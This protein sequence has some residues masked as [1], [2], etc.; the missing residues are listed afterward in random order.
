[1]LENEKQAFTSISTNEEKKNAENV[2]LEVVEINDQGVN[3]ALV[4]KNYEQAISFFRRA[5]DIGPECY[6]CRYNL[7]RAFL[8]TENFDKSAAVF[9]E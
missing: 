2:S 8:K 1:M 9:T 4:E 3:K 6:T 7:G 5:V